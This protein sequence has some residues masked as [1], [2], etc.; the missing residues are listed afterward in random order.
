[1][2]IPSSKIS[3]WELSL[4]NEAIFKSNLKNSIDL[5]QSRAC[6]RWQILHAKN[7]KIVFDVTAPLRVTRGIQLTFSRSFS[8]T[9]RI[10]KNEDFDGPYLEN[11]NELLKN[12]FETVFRA[13]ESG[14]RG[15]LV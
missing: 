1:M 4:F 12:S 6:C 5:A 15:Q 14:D 10:R 11:E 7:P 2:L 3:F 8:E 13:S 9:F